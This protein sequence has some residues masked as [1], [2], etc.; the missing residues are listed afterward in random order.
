MT[1]GDGNYGY[2]GADDSFVPFSSGTIKEF[3]YF[4][5]RPYSYGSYQIIGGIFIDEN[6]DLITIPSSTAKADFLAM[7]DLIKDYYF[8]N[9]TSITI[10]REGYYMLKDATN[11]DAVTV[12][13]YNVDDTIS[14]AGNVASPGVTVLYLGETNP[15][16]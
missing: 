1:D 5:N 14:L 2:R 16:A 10:G 3:L 7:Q 15:F 4:A 13:H 11:F 12:T 9:P 6:G 8:S